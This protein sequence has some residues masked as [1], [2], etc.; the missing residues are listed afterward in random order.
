[1][2]ISTLTGVKQPLSGRSTAIRCSADIV[3][4][5]G[6]TAKAMDIAAQFTLGV[7]K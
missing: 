4:I 7:Y 3:L 2:R 6:N 5:S 1:M